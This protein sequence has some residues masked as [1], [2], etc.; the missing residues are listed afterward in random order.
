MKRIDSPIQPSLLTYSGIAECPIFTL[1]DLIREIVSRCWVRGL[2]TCRLLS[3]KFKEFADDKLVEC[4]NNSQIIL[5]SRENIRADRSMNFKNWTHIV[6]FFKEME[7]VKR[8][9]VQEFPIDEPSI[10]GIQKNFNGFKSLKMIDGREG[11]KS[12]LLEKEGLQIYAFSYDLA[13]VS[14]VKSFT[15]LTALLV[16][17]CGDIRGLNYISCCT[18]LT[19]LNIENSFT[20]NISFAKNLPLEFVCLEQCAH[21]DDFTPLSY[22]TAIKE[23]YLGST[24][25]SAN[26]MESLKDL[27]LEYLDVS[28]CT[29]AEHFNLGYFTKLKSL[30][31]SGTSIANADFLTNL[32]QLK[33]LT[34]DACLDIDHNIIANLSLE[35]LDFSQNNLQRSPCLESNTP[36]SVSLTYLSLENSLVT[37]LTFLEHFKALS[38]EDK[39]AIAL[40][41]KVDPNII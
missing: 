16:M 33:V 17:D 28:G 26:D 19:F 21:I 41:V 8:L 34:A 1:D 23:L 11:W 39:E 30:R 25:I 35:N 24:N 29:N 40:E 12:I 14:F 10:E 18:S 38:L 36:L 4:I 7:G 9:S 20:T 37:D 32:C 31:I 6:E 15:E 27:Q 2:L 3:R 22:C 5:D 13:D